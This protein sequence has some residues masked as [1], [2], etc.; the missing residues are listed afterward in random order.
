[1]PAGQ[2][3]CCGTHEVALKLLPLHDFVPMDLRQVLVE[4]FL[5]FIFKNF[6]ELDFEEIMIFESKGGPFDAKF[7]KIEKNLIFLIEII[8]FLAESEFYM[9]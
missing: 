8:L 5:G 9:I 2:E 6:E 3:M 1:M 7:V 4:S